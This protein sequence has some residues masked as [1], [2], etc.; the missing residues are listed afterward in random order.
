MKKQNP[1]VVLYHLINPPP[2][3]PPM[4]IPT[5]QDQ[6]NSAKLGLLEVKS[7]K[8]YQAALE[9][10]LEKKVRRLSGELERA[11]STAEVDRITAQAVTAMRLERAA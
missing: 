4:Y 6:L 2:P 5:L 7:E 9:D 10:A 3:P 1:L 8:E 11:I